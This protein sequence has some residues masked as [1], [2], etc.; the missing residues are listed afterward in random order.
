[1]GPSNPNGNSGAGGGSIILNV[2]T[3][4]LNGQIKVDG[5]NGVCTNGG[6]GAGGSVFIQ[7]QTFSGTS[8]ALISS[9]GGT[10]SNCGYGN[11]ELR[12]FINKF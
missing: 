5:S 2:S 12:S 10:G 8:G 6:G 1:M 7:A 11:D 9:N 4:V 3:L